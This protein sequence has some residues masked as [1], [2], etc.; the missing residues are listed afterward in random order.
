MRPRVQRGTLCEILDAEEGSFEDLKRRAESPTIQIKG[1]TVR[2]CQFTSKP[3]T[4]NNECRIHRC[5]ITSKLEEV[6][7]TFDDGNIRT[8][9]GVPVTAMFNALD[10]TTK[11][12]LQEKTYKKILCCWLHRKRPTTRAPWLAVIDFFEASRNRD[13]VQFEKQY[14]IV[15]DDFHRSDNIADRTGAISIDFGSSNNAKVSVVIN[16]IKDLPPPRARVT[17]RRDLSNLVEEIQDIIREIGSSVHEVWNEEQTRQ[18]SEITRLNRTLATMR[19]NLASANGTVDLNGL[20]TL[21]RNAEAMRDKIQG[22]AEDP[23]P[24]ASAEPLSN[25]VRGVSRAVLG[26]VASAMGGGAKRAKP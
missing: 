25:A 3:R 24:A 17:N 18:D 16:N 14:R 2:C 8:Y 13:R 12:A 1:K 23:E 21:K 4:P 19:T 20:R 9:A 22:T 10:V 15:R 6:D 11:Q 26:V 7:G 5:G